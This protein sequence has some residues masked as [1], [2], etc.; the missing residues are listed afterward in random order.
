LN[1]D[2]ELVEPEVTSRTKAIFPIYYAGVPAEMDR[3]NGIAQNHDL[4]VVEDAAQAIGSK[5]NGCQVGALGD[6]T[7]Q[8]LGFM[9]L[10]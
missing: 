4:F 7:N 5:Y 1:I 10:R 3:L 9:R 6:T 8:M 2:E